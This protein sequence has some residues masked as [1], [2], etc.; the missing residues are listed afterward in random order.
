MPKPTSLTGWW[1]KLL[2]TKGQGNVGLLASLIPASPRLLNKWG[3]GVRPSREN[4]RNIQQLA[5]KALLS[6]EDCPKYLRKKKKMTVS[7]DD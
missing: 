7:A 3:H 1:L 4:I 6:Q 5:G 2:K